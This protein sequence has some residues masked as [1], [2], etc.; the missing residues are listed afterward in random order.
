MDFKV[1]VTCAVRSSQN[2]SKTQKCEY[3]NPSQ[4]KNPKRFAHLGREGIFSVGT[5][6]KAGLGQA[7]KFKFGGEGME[8]P[9]SSLRTLGSSSGQF[10]SLFISGD[11]LSQLVASSIIASYL[12]LSC[13]TTALKA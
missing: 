6:D 2:S 8:V 10:F 11:S 1:D 3:G 4:D 12:A 13:L 5:R 7:N 9:E